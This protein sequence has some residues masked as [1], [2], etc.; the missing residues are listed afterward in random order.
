VDFDLKKKHKTLLIL[1]LYALGGS[2][3]LVKRIC[4]IMIHD[5]VMRCTKIFAGT[6]KKTGCT[7]P[8][9]AQKK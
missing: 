7:K 3:T 5:L 4:F 6:Q 8:A 1:M 2:E 9:Q